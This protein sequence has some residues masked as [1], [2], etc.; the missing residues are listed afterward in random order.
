MDRTVKIWRIPPSVFTEQ[1]TATLA[2]EDKPLFT[3]DL[4]HKARVLFISWFVLVTHLWRLYDSLF[5]RLDDDILISASAPALMRENPM[6]IDKTYWED[7]TG[8]AVEMLVVM[9]LL[10]SSSH[11]MAMARIESILSSR[12]DTSENHEGYS[13]CTSSFHLA[14]LTKYRYSSFRPGLA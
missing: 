1:P 11:G 10:N 13:Q 7:G 6:E 14:H 4:I 3:T 12:E 5:G 9:R 2:R 8:A